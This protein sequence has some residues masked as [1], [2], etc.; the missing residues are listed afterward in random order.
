QGTVEEWYLINATME[1]HAFH[2][3]QMAFVQ[4]RDYTGIPVTVDTVFV[5]VGKLLP[6]PRNPNYPLIQPSI[7]KLILDFRH[8]PKGTF[9]F[10][11]HMLFHEDHGMMGVIRVE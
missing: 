2:I 10:H 3:H 6:N 11:C 9:V 7:T 8:V 5:P 1:T 4:E